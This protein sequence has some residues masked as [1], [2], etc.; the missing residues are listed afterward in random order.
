MSACP[1][2]LLELAIAAYC[3]LLKKNASQLSY[4]AP[5][6]SAGRMR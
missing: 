6:N 5:A 1:W 3:G 4:T 2:Q